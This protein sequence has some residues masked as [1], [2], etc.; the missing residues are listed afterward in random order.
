MVLRFERFCLLVLMSLCVQ[1]AYAD[2]W[3]DTMIS[4]AQSR[5]DTRN[6]SGALEAAKYALKR[7]PTDPTMLKIAAKSSLE[8]S[9]Y[10][11]AIDYA[12]K[13]IKQSPSSGE[14]YYIK[15][16][17]ELELKEYDKALADGV[18]AGDNGYSQGLSVA[19]AARQKID[20][21]NRNDEN[22]YASA[23][24]VATSGAYRRYLNFF[25]KGIHAAE[26]NAMIAECELWEK[27]CA[28]DT[29]EAYEHYLATTVKNRFT[30]LANDKLLS[31]KDDD[32]WIVIASSWNNVELQ[33]YIN[34]YPNGKHL[35]TVRSRMIANAAHEEYVKRNYTRAYEL[36]SQAL[37]ALGE[38]PYYP[39]NVEFIISKSYITE[40]TVNTE[41]SQPIPISVA[42]TAAPALKQDK[43]RQR[44]HFGIEGGCEFAAYSMDKAIGVSVRYG[45]HDRTF[46][47]SVGLNWY[48]MRDLKWADKWHWFAPQ[49]GVT[50]H[51]LV[52]PIDLRLNLASVYQR[53]VFLTMATGFDFGMNV[54]NRED[55]R[56]SIAYRI[57][58]GTTSSHFAW[59]IYYKI[60]FSGCT[61]YHGWG[62]NADYGRLG[63]KLAY[64][65]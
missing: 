12:T 53:K 28:D 46:N 10:K 49:H 21:A 61:P 15:A 25:P 8:L 4:Q 22:F 65:F 42:T 47:A 39:Y 33:R 6:Y 35:T 44:F 34:N 20:E 64:Y 14:A 54:T 24:R 60:H 59:S 9:Q 19:N 17:S 30:P 16:K 63:F 7:H 58:M 11:N 50:L 62:R 43:P 1:F 52:I 13:W 18:R 26:A 29:R 5:Y 57:G 3:L 37:I 45:E 55:M 48:F 36:Y 31:L 40:Q 51:Q 56:T 41:S 23:D 27:T 32:E 2:K 38:L